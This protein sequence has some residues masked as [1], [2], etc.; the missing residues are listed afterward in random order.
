MTMAKK[1]AAVVAHT[2]NN[3]WGIKSEFPKHSMDAALRVARALEDRNGGNPLPPTE[4]A[5]AM[6]ISPGSS[7][8]RALISSSFRY[9]LTDGSYKSARV[10][11]TDLGRR[12]VAPLSSEDQHRAELQAAF[13]PSTFQ[14]MY[15]FLK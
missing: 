11:L 12:V 5:I 13:T 6:G 2:D 3:R 9:G 14:A 4:L 8:L 1:T 15:E 10:S 7:E